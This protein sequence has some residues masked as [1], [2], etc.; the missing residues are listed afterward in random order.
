MSDK[1]RVRFEDE[2]S[3][4]PFEF[5]LVRF[6]ND[7][8]KYSWP[9]SYRNYNVQCA[10]EGFQFGY[11]SAIESAAK[12]ASVENCDHLDDAVVLTKEQAANICTMIGK[13]DYAAVLRSNHD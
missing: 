12:A 6:P 1:L 2:F 3:K 4:S 8:S 7:L 13:D 11:K 10:W 5:D 9:G